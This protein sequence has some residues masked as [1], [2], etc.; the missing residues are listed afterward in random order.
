MTK[1]ARILLRSV[2]ALLVFL[3][4]SDLC[5]I[6]IGGPFT[7]DTYYLPLRDI[8]VGKSR[9]LIETTII[10]THTAAVKWEHGILLIAHLLALLMTLIALKCLGKHEPGLRPSDLR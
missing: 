2:I 5:A 10:K 1:W 8:D 3:A 9:D 4:F 7:A 6:G